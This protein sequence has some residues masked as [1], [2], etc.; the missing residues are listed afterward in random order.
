[1]ESAI[2]PGW[3]WLF[4]LRIL[5]STSALTGFVEP[6]GICLWVPGHTVQTADSC[7]WGG[8]FLRQR[9]S[10]KLWSQT[11][12]SLLQ[13][14]SEGIWFCLS[15]GHLRAALGSLTQVLPL[16]THTLLLLLICPSWT[17]LLSYFW[18]F[19]SH[20]SS[21]WVWLGMTG[22][23]SLPLPYWELHHIKL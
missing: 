9:P 5:G 2:T 23:N 22:F 3:F 11:L 12:S 16:L 20:S 6:S 17:H 8:S 1:M 21:V 13:H 10:C 14:S 4:S 18:F 7:Y 19:L 15:A